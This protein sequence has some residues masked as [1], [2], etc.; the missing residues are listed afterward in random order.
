MTHL[1]IPHE[2]YSNPGADHAFTDYNRD[3]YQKEA[4]DVDRPR[5]LAF[6]GAHFTRVA[7]R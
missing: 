4:F 3:R 7:V 5:I 6:F 1:G 2:F